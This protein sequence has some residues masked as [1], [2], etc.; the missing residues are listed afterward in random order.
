MTYWTISTVLFVLAAYWL[1]MAHGR[2]K[3]RQRI[4]RHTELVQR[5]LRSA[6]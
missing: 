3:E 4:R 5:M 2:A 6:R 1:G